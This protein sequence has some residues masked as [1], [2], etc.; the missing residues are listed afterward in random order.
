MLRSFG[1]LVHFV[2]VVLVVVGGIGLV[3][4]LKQVFKVRLSTL[5]STAW[6]L[7]MLL[8]VAAFVCVVAAV[9]G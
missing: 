6:L 7:I 8:A 2:T 1:A 3:F 9:S 4:I 5:G